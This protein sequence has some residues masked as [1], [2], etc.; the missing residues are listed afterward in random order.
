MCRFGG[1]FWSLCFLG[2]VGGNLLSGGLSYRWGAVGFVGCV[3]RCLVRVGLYLRLVMVVL[4]YFPWTVV[5]RGGGWYNISVGLGRWGWVAKGLGLYCFVKGSP[6]CRFCD[7]SDFDVFWV[8]GC[9]CLHWRYLF[10]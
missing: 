4:G 2:C 9:W 7:A 8:Y 3:A 5:L 1:G 10:E 6:E